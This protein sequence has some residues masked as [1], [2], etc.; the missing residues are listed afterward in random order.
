MLFSVLCVILCDVCYC[1]LCVIVV[2]LSPG[3]NSLAVIN[4]IYIYICKVGRD[5]SVGIVTRYELNGPGFESRW[6]RDFQHPSRLALGPTQPPTQWVP[7][8]SRG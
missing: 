2:P 5:S 8:H 7:G 1:V 4:Y 3:I 6:G